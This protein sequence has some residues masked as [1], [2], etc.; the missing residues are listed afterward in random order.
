MKYKVY[1]LTSY[2]CH[3]ILE[4]GICCSAKDGKGDGGMEMLAFHVKLGELELE[5]LLLAAMAVF[6]CLAFAAAAVQ[7]YLEK[8]DADKPERFYEGRVLEKRVEAVGARLL[9]IEVR[10]EWIIFETG[11]GERLCLRNVRPKTLLIEPGDRAKIM[12]KGETICVF[13]RKF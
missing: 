10:V 2:K 11:G 13:A 6:A 1:N 7:I 5:T 8:A 12:V 4:S 9:G 3:S